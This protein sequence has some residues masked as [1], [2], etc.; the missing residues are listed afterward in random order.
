MNIVDKLRK[1][2]QVIIDKVKIFNYSQEEITNILKQNTRLFLKKI[3]LK[4]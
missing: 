3:I 4:N 2:N 1:S